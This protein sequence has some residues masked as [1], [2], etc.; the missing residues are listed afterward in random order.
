M[1]KYPV[2]TC[3]DCFHAIWVWSE[4]KYPE[5]KY[6]IIVQEPGECKA[7][8]SLANTSDGKRRYINAMKPYTDYTSWS[9]II[10]NTD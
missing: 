3:R 1:S 10:E 7:E 4:R 2:C 8:I 9:P 6:R 5:G